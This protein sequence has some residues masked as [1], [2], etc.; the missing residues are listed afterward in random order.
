MPE[1]S[2]EFDGYLLISSSWGWCQKPVVDNGMNPNYQPQLGEWVYRIS[3]KKHPVSIFGGTKMRKNSSGNLW[4]W[5]FLWK[6]IQPPTL[7][8]SCFVR[9]QFCWN[10]CH[11][12]KT[13]GFGVPSFMMCG[14][15][16][17]FQKTATPPEDAVNCPVFQKPRDLHWNHGCFISLP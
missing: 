3:K 5:L 10:D 9:S 13:L 4:I 12:G 14:F 1:P 7:S 17:G 16:L 6:L 11:C 15:I 2:L 8:D